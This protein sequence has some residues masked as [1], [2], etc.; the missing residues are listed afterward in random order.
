MDPAMGR[1]LSLVLLATFWGPVT[2][3]N[4][5]N[6]KMC[7]IWTLN[8]LPPVLASKV[9]PG[10]EG[11]I[12]SA[13]SSTLS[14]EGKISAQCLTN[15][16]WILSTSQDPMNFCV[17][18]DPL[19]DMLTVQVDRE[20]IHVCPSL[21][22]QGSCC[23]DLSAAGQ[24]MSSVYGIKDGSVHGDLLNS[25]VM[26][27]YKFKGDT[28]NCAEQFCSKAV[29]ESWGANMIEEAV[30]QSGVVGRVELPCAQGTVIEMKEDF[31]GYNVTLPTPGSVP[32]HV[33]PSVHLPASLKPA[34]KKNAKVVC[35]YYKN[36]SLFQVSSQK[37]LEDVV[38]ITVENEIIRNL[39]EPVRIMFRH[40]DILETQ[41]TKCVSWD[42]RKD[43]ELKWREEGCVTVHRGA[44]ETECHCN[45]LTYFAILVQVNPRRLRHLEALTFITAVGCALSAVSCVLVFVALCR[46]RRRGK[47]QSSLVHRGLVV[48][49]FFLCLLFMLTGTVANVSH[50][51]VCQFMGALLHYA[52]LC[53]LCWMA[54]EVLHTF[55][56]VYMIFSVP[57]KPWIWYLMG[58]G[59]PVLPVVI[60][61]SM[62]NIYGPRTISQ[63]EDVANPYHMCWMRDTHAALLAHCITNVGLLAAVVT[64]GFIMLFLVVRE[65]HNR[66][67]WRK[68]RVAFLSIWGLSCL[69]GTT[70]G[71][72]FFDFGP[73]SEIILFLFCII[74]SLQGFF[75]M[76]RFYVL[77]R[78]Q[79]QSE[80]ATDG[81]S[82]GSTRQHMLQT[83]E[84]N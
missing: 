77:A 19:L 32:P 5:R 34:Q 17:F 57:P 61:V 26:A 21:G 9:S 24:K 8:S 76:L 58:F 16:R 66:T 47:D 78:M 83:Q 31:T 39:P 56:M 53:S 65:I 80:Y 50:E 54:V 35:T 42:V 3:E 74:N 81:S 59:F 2:M 22:L 55:R 28:I 30:I 63:S 7:G 11:I 37:I 13:N 67:E 70:W 69:F 60:L 71:L 15:R 10:C 23:T 27:E 84:R 44:Q 79:S 1:V 33:F 14:V 73:L 4:D 48:S 6:F 72:T 64:S 18:W 41:T 51:R 12:I 40:A 52:L 46:Q 29:Q 75:L 43:H 62:G 36:S 20:E 82:T 49:L 25:R 68:R 45:H 38:G